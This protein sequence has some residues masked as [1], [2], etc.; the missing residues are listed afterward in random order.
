M[1]KAALTFASFFTF[2]LCAAQNNQTIADIIE[3]NAG[4]DALVGLLQSTFADYRRFFNLLS[5]G[6]GLTLF[7]PNGDAFENAPQ[8]V[9]ER[10]EQDDFISHLQDVLLYHIA[11]GE[12][13]SSDL[14]GVNTSNVETFSYRNTFEN[15]TMGAEV[16]TLLV[17]MV[18]TATVNDE[19]NIVN[20]FDV[21]ASDGVVHA[22]DQL[23]LPPSARYSIVDVLSFHPERFSILLEL[24]EKAGLLNMLSTV[25]PDGPPLTLFTPTNYAFRQLPQS[26]VTALALPANT[27]VLLEIL[28]YHSVPGV[29]EV[30]ELLDRSSG[31][32]E[33]LQGERLWLNLEQ[34]RVNDARIIVPDFLVTNGVMHFV[35]KVL[36]PSSLESW[37]NDQEGGESLSGSASGK[38]G[39]KKSDKKKSKLFK[40]LKSKKSSK[41]NKGSKVKGASKQKSE[42]SG[43]RSKT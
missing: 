38:S 24:V 41:A 16:N 40:K 39:R 35:T 21:V 34:G 27:D 43:K 3:S 15:D 33:S 19:A 9:L 26:V 12:Y 22:V 36:A 28:S 42:K 13:F 31:Y 7:A 5:D 10:L 6:V 8:T 1:R 30:T 20:P 11:S 17:S 32:V 29:W 14:V 25:P 4:F 18:P 23:L 2:H 37:M